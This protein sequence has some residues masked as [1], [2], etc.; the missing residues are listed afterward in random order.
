MLVRDNL[1]VPYSKTCCMNKCLIDWLFGCQL[2]KSML[3]ANQITV[4]K[5]HS[6]L[7]KLDL[8]GTPIRDFYIKLLSTG[9]NKNCFHTQNLHWGF[10]FCY[11]FF[12]INDVINKRKE[13]IPLHHS[14]KAHAIWMKLAKENH[15][16]NVIMNPT[17]NSFRF[18]SL[19]FFKVFHNHDMI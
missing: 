4:I 7:L 9:S 12:V 6:D 15:N 18:D 13:K 17:N 1:V 8:Y 10:W 16:L 19:R 5:S 3:N 14:Q 11:C 2:K